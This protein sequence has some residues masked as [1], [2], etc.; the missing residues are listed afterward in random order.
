MHE[1]LFDQNSKLQNENQ[2]LQEVLKEELRKQILLDK[3]LKAKSTQPNT[4][5]TKSVHF[6]GCTGSFTTSQG[7]TVSPSS[8]AEETTSQQRAN[9]T[10]RIKKTSRARKRSSAPLELVTPLFPVSILKKTTTIDVSDDNTDTP[11]Q[12]ETELSNL[13]LAEISDDA[14]DEVDVSDSERYAALPIRDSYLSSLHDQVAENSRDLEIEQRQVQ[15][16]IVNNNILC[17]KCIEGSTKLKGHV[18]R[19]QRSRGSI[20][21]AN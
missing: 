5:Q 14:S 3:A 6:T 4:V 19:H 18:G 15:D 9:K 21:T 7:E 16:D 1:K 10:R 17:D 8:S 11:S 2:K 12:T 20:T 13:N